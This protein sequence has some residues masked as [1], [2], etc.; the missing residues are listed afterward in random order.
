M[1]YK[2]LYDKK[3]ITA[4]DAANM[5]NDGDWV[6]LGWAALIPQEFDKALAARANELQD[7]KIRSGIATYP[8]NVTQAD[9]TGEHFIYHSY[10]S[11]AAER[12][13][14]EKNKYGAFH[15]CARYG[16]AGILYSSVT[17]RSRVFV[18][19]ARPMDKHGNFNFGI[20]TSH[21]REI[22]E[23]S[24]CVIIEVNENVPRALGGSYNFV[25][26]K[27]VDYII[28]SSNYPMRTIPRAQFDH[29]ELDVARN[30]MSILQDRDCIQLGI[31]GLPNAIGSEIVN[32]DLKDLGVHSEMYVDAFMDLTK[33]GKISGKYKSRDKGRQVYAFA[34]GTA[35]L[36][37]FIDDNEELMATS[38]DYVND[39]ATIS[40]IDN[41]VSVN[42]AISVDLWGQVSSETVGTRH[43]SGT[44]GALDFMLGAY[45]SRGGRSVVALLS[46]KVDS[47]GNR[48]SNI[49]PTLPLGTQ[50]TATRST[51][52]YVA[53]E[54]GIVNLKGRSAWQRAEL[55]ISLAHPELRD[56]L[57]QQADEMGM[58]RN[59][60]K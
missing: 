30:V 32:S 19:Q 50:A 24:D 40:S 22:M 45:K 25:N 53:T 48:Y 33:A 3:L 5:V 55:L 37:E 9:F 6:D 46:S 52:Q 23:N 27:D 43:I 29:Y 7:V 57:I 49:M 15:T 2:E 28:E 21:T 4:E 26:I 42:N 11:T 44:G 60:N 47:E 38:V 51:V 54:Y 13:F 56:E 41:F 1:D 14:I 36:Y 20:A 34:G 8:L 17:E 35:E 12:P 59:S 58:W 10:F 16:E 31:G 18:I 39:V